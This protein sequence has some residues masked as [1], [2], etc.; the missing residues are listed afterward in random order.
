[1]ISARQQGRERR[2]VAEF[3]CPNTM[4]NALK[5]NPCHTP[6]LWR[7]GWGWTKPRPLVHPHKERQA[8]VP[9]TKHRSFKEYQASLKPIP[10]PD[11]E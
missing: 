6:R 11:G 9:E 4:C 1:M 8:L 7:E 2:A 10:R 3:A 5:G